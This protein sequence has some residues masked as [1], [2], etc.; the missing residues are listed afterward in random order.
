MTKRRKEMEIQRGRG[1][2]ETARDRGRET[3]T[4]VKEERARERAA[5]SVVLVKVTAAECG[6]PEGTPLC[7]H[8][9]V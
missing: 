1:G 5:V 8:L 6:D 4:E 7:V 2:E 3:L 9:C